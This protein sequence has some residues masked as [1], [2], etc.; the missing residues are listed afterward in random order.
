MVFI[1]AGLEHGG[2]CSSHPP[3]RVSGS[4]RSAIRAPE[5]PRLVLEA[6]ASSA[7]DD[8]VALESGGERHRVRI[9]AFHGQ[10][11]GLE[12]VGGGRVSAGD[13]VYSMPDFQLPFGEKLDIEGKCLV[14]IPG[15]GHGQGAGRGL[16][17]LVF[18]V[19][20]S[21][22]SSGVEPTADFGRCSYSTAAPLTSRVRR[23]GRQHLRI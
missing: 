16:C 18:E 14:G 13:A 3:R 8:V 4:S 2:R 10:L 12:R 20:S 22:V 9:V 11:R 19:S 21:T 5:P 23:R 7:W 15:Q 17:A 1:S 6:P